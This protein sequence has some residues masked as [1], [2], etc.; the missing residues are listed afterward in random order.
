MCR[1]G[2]N[3]CL[4]FICHKNALVFTSV[5]DMKPYVT[6]QQSFEEGFHNVTNIKQGGLFISSQDI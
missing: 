1:L 5:L 4:R 3:P 2:A 6:F